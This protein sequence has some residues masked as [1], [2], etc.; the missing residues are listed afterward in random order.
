[1]KMYFTD[2][3]YHFIY[4]NKC[5]NDVLN[6]TKG[7]KFYSTSQLS[8]RTKLKEFVLSEIHNK[9]KLFN[10]IDSKNN[11]F[12]N[13]CSNPVTNFIYNNQTYKSNHK[14]DNVPIIS[15]KDNKIIVWCF[16]TGL[17][18]NYVYFEF[19]IHESLFVRKFYIEN[20]TI[21]YIN[22]TLPLNINKYDYF[23]VSL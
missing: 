7:I 3:I 23:N 18:F 5:L 1:M 15:C 19:V 2:L 8:D 11:E 21:A 22:E 4:G 17:K 6:T 10:S 13:L 9:V 14:V 20:Q 12:V 16:F